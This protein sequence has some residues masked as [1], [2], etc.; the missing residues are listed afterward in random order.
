MNRPVAPTTV[1]N[2][3]D[4][5]TDAVRSLS[6]AA[7]RSEGRAPARNIGPRDVRQLPGEVRERT[8]NRPKPNEFDR[9]PHLEISEQLLNRAGR[10]ERTRKWI[11]TA[12]WIG[13]AIALIGSIAL[14]WTQ[15]QSVSINIFAS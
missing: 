9:R 8:L 2:V 12:L 15:L 14:F 3:P 4:S 11:R 5:Q 10:I 6:L 1:A 13:V 7:V